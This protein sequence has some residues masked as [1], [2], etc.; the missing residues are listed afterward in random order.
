M[1][2]P[3]CELIQF[4]IIYRVRWRMGNSMSLPKGVQL[5]NLFLLFPSSSHPSP[6]LSPSLSPPPLLVKVVIQ[7]LA[8]SFLWFVIF[9]KGSGTSATTDSNK[10]NNVFFSGP[11]PTDTIRGVS[12]LYSES[13][14][15]FAPPQITFTL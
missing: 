1:S 6:F 14:A 4:I 12:G 10:T 15:L 7:F 3:L 13:R 11:F 5:W 9:T 2:S 8:A